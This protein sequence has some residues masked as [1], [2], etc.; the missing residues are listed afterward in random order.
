MFE[1]QSHVTRLWAVLEDMRAG[2]IVRPASLGSYG[3]CS[4]DVA[5]LWRSVRL[6]V[7]LGAVTVWVPSGIRDPATLALGRIG[8]D[9]ARPSPESRFLLD[10]YERIASVAWTLRNPA[11]PEPAVEGL[12]VAERVNWMGREAAFDLATG[13]LA[14]GRAGPRVPCGPMPARLVADPVGL[15]AWQGRDARGLDG[16]E[17]AA[18][19]DASNGLAHR[20][21]SAT[22]LLHT[23][24]SD[25]HVAVRD[26]IMAMERP[27]NPGKRLAGF[28]ES[29]S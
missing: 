15:V 16:A 5:A 2:R 17:A 7:P 24:R 14:I 29:L 9:A 27:G 26:A 10:G 20:Y 28:V 8:P 21:R 3:W 11:R 1:I 19:R 12:S 4:D 13:E 23:M 6:G 18:R 22:V 25:D